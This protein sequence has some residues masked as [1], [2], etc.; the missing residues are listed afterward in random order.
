VSFTRLRTWDWVAFI[1]AL[2]LLFVTAVDWYSTVGGDEARRIERLSQPEGALGG[3]V[4][5]EVQDSARLAA[6]GQEKN[7]WQVSG[8]IDRVILIGL[9]V[10]A[11]LGVLS[12][13]TAAS[14]RASRSAI[15]PAGLTGIAATVTALLVVYRVMQEPGFDEATTVKLGAPL[16]L[17][18]LGV[19]AFASATVLRRE[20]E[21]PAG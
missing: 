21:P 4:E 13:F 16:A 2:A 9:L 1:A 17:V 12:G 10:T 18:V 7:A 19:V 15:P 20:P 5:R 11:L 14:G 6:E 8:A 3:Q